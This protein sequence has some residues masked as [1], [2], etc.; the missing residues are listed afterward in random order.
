MTL[1]VLFAV[2]SVCQCFLLDSNCPHCNWNGV[3]NTQSGKCTCYE[4]FK[5]TDC[6][7]DCGCQ[8]HGV[9][10]QDNTCVC[11]SGWKWSKSLHK[12]VWDCSCSNGV[13]CIGPGVCDCVHACKYGTCW[14]GQCECWEGYKGATCNVF[15]KNIM[16]NRNISVGMN[17]GGLSY[18]SPELKFVDIV[19]QSQEW[20]TEH[21][22]THQW[23]THEHD[24]ITWRDDGYPAS[25]PSDMLVGKLVLRASAG[26]HGPQGNFTLLYD[27]DGEIGFSLVRY[28]IHYNG[29]GRMLVEFHEGS[30]GI[31]IKIMRTNS[32][33]PVH[34]IRLILPGFEDRHELFPFYPPFLENIK[35]YSELRFMDMLHTNGHT[36]EPTTWD[37]RR[38]QNFHTQTGTKGCAIEYLIHLTNIVGAD[39]WFNQPHAA[40]DDFIR[41]FANMTKASLR[42]ELK[43]Y[44]E[45][46]NE[47]WNGIF[48]QTKYSKQEGMKLGLDTHDWKAGLKFYN[49]RSTETVDLWKAVFGSDS[50]RLI[51]VWAWQTGYH[52]YTRQ[53][54]VDLGTRA[55]HFK[56]LAITG[57]FGCD[58]VTSQSK[59]DITQLS[60]A[61]IRALCKKDLPKSINDFHY[62]MN[63]SKTYNLKLLMYE[64]GPGLESSRNNNATDHA[65]AF[66]R[67]D[68]AEDATADV[69]EAWYDI[70]TAD[71]YNT[72]PGGLFNYFA[73]VSTYSKYGSWGMMEFTGQDPYTSPK[74]L[75]VHRYINRHFN[76]QYMGPACS[77]VLFN[78]TVYGC[79]RQN[80]QNV[81]C[82]MSTDHGTHWTNYPLLSTNTSALILDGY[83]VINHA[84]FVRNVDDIAVNTFY[85][86]DTSQQYLQ[87]KS[88][89]FS[90]YYRL[91]SPATVRRRM[92]NGDHHGIN[93]NQLDC[94]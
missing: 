81:H 87:W 41:H 28:T 64:G 16:M 80:N 6:S 4:G 11:D 94:N 89:T 78:N 46:S 30:G 50:D 84:I 88:L 72:H 9:C 71:P 21:H 2:L 32:K 12:C 93:I 57:Y 83:D 63:M 42:P 14:N 19:K 69:L 79:Y 22:T 31:F 18:W 26:T 66:N 59:H 68:L 33:N 56:G 44:I 90:D 60:M 7:T 82:G 70:V 37:T 27:G 38:L 13:Q 52:D 15:D 20:I 8:G 85:T 24:T 49:K 53:A 55:S 43:M 36:P 58:H 5:G 61:D 39:P 25:L 10:T 65:I 40:D 48:Q 35:R 17:L 67:H 29:K 77:F 54:I 86:M 23:D 62:F 73:S 34:N 76:N 75:A 3:C 74:Y 91:V 51:P 45:Y 47:V 92:T 1:L